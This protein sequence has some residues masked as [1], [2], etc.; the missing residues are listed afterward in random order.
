MSSS[1]DEKPKKSS[2][3]KTA[4]KQPHEKEQDTGK[5]LR[6]ISRPITVSELLPEKIMNVES[7]SDEHLVDEAFSKI[8][9]IFTKH[10]GSALEEV[11]VYLFEKFYEN[12]VED[13][14][15]QKPTK[16]LE[17][18]SLIRKI[19]EFDDRAP[20]Q[21]WF[22]D[23]VSIAADKLQFQKLN[24][25]LYNDAKITPS[26]KVHIARIKKIE[27]KKA[28]IQK[29]IDENLSVRALKKLLESGKNKMDLLQSTEP[30]NLITMQPSEIKSFLPRI[31][32][33]IT[34]LEREKKAIEDKISQYEQSKRT[35]EETIQKKL[36]ASKEK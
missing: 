19:T 10:F 34:S 14:Q 16:A 20:S 24:Y 12:N 26:H 8:G 27:D 30:S 6:I 11:G 35:V 25:E 3:K 1:T 13:A 15:K 4:T 28:A 9:E 17:W 31:D 33:K 5:N 21:S 23:A 2:G 32:K 7:E 36:E 29:T 18:K 22:Y